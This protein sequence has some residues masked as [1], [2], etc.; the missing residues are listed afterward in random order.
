VSDM[1]GII[2][3]EFEIRLLRKVIGRHVG[4]GACGTRD[5]R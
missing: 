3:S 1:K 4:E 5:M 2:L